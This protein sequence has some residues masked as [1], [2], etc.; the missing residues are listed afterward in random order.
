MLENKPVLKKVGIG[1]L[2]GLGILLVVLA[3]GGVKI[4]FDVKKAGGVEPYIRQKSAEELQVRTSAAVDQL[5]LNQH[6]KESITMPVRQLAGRI[7]KN[8]FDVR[9]SN[10]LLVNAL[11][12]PALDALLALLFQMRQVDAHDESGKL[13][14]NRFAWGALNGKIRDTEPVLQLLLAD[15]GT[16]ADIRRNGSPLTSE[17]AQK[18]QIKEKLSVTDRN[19]CLERMKAAADRAGIAPLRQELDFAPAIAK[20]IAAAAAAPLPPPPVPPGKP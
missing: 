13:A 20:I 3:A 14:V 16:L 2:V 5:P 1:C 10:L 19:Q 4:Y 15:P 7:A 6:E 8:E 11:Q 9:R 18:L 17:R 12:S